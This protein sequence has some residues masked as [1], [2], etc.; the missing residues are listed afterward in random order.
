[1]SKVLHASG[2]ALGS[3]LAEA[4][5]PLLKQVASSGSYTH[6]VAGHTAFGRDVVPRAAALLDASQ[7][8]DITAVHDADTFERPIYAGNAIAKVKSADKLKV[9][10]V[11]GTAFDKAATEGGSASAEKVDFAEPSSE[12][13][14][15]EACQRAASGE[16]KPGRG[17]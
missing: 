11:R 12:W 6:V 2:E 15:C 1:V 16:V 10:T 3:S 5:A 4:F 7:I 17:L 14:E 9:L 8:S 13:R